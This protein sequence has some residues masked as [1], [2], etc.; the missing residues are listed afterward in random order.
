MS[1]PPDKPGSFHRPARPGR[2]RSS[3][4]GP[5]PPLRFARYRRRAVAE[6]SFPIHENHPPVCPKCLEQDSLSQGRAVQSWQKKSLSL[7][8]AAKIQ[9]GLVIEDPEAAAGNHRHDVS[10]TEAYGRVGAD[11]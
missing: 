6:E 11:D 10:S 4:S 7:A 5:S 9:N 2:S 3:G 1:E 8:E